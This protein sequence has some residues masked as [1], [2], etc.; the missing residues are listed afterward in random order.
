MLEVVRSSEIV[1]IT[2]GAFLEDLISLKRPYKVLNKLVQLCLFSMFKR[3]GNEQVKRHF[4]SSDCKS[5]ASYCLKPAGMV[6]I[7]SK[8]FTPCL[9]ITPEEECLHSQSV[10]SKQ[11]NRERGL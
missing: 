5:Q 10:F 2:S 8:L 7:Y 4:P 9:P 6:P 3:G 1:L 11:I